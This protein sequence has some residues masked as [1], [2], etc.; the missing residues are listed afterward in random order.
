MRTSAIVP[1]AAAKSNQAP[2]PLPLIWNSASW[3]VREVPAFVCTQCGDASID[4]LMAGKLESLV[5]K[6]RRKQALV[7][8]TQW[9]QE[10]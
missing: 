6:A 9:R 1:C 5:A 7:E 4:D 8:V 2:Q 10:A 3:V